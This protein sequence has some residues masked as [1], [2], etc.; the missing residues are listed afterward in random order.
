VEVRMKVGRLT[1]T[2]EAQRLGNRVRR[3][4]FELGWLEREIASELGISR[5]QVQYFKNRQKR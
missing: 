4:Y 2:E 1:N 3:L 5:S